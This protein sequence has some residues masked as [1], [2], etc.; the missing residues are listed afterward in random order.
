MATISASFLPQQ[1][2]NRLNLDLCNKNYKKPQKCGCCANKMPPKKLNI[3]YHHHLFV[4]PCIYPD[5]TNGLPS[6][7]TVWA[8]S[9]CVNMVN[10]V[11]KSGQVSRVGS[12]CSWRDM[13]NSARE[14][15]RMTKRA[16]LG[17]TQS[18]LWP[19]LSFFSCHFVI[20]INSILNIF[21][22]ASRLSAL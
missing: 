16:I 6:N 8:I 18:K 5:L 3:L 14:Q 21:N 11:Q 2:P 17:W 15:G 10:T 9:N 1:E 19:V 22:I 7:P 13:S 20:I 12:H 4:R